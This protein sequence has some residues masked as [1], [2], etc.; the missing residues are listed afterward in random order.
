MKKLFSLFITFM[1]F[2]V[3]ISLLL[4]NLVLAQ[5][6]MYKNI[7]NRTV[8]T[9]DEGD[10]FITI[11]EGSTKT[12]KIEDEEFKINLMMISELD[13]Y[14]LIR[15]DG[16]SLPKMKTGDFQTSPK[17]IMIG[18]VQTYLTSKRSKPSIAKLVISKKRITAKEII[19][20]EKTEEKFHIN[21]IVLNE[22]GNIEQKEI[23]TKTEPE[24]NNTAKEIKNVSPATSTPAIT[25]A[26]KSAT[27]IATTVTPV[28][29]KNVTSTATKLQQK[30]VQEQKAKSWW[31]KILD[32]FYLI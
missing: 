11:N 30:P 1:A 29:R 13:G 6:S 16:E 5:E 23:E 14:V 8:E 19:E 18:V 9:L 12:L 31:Q 32:F 20:G 17:G 7:L 24:K 4:I 25:P 28:E 2:I 10:P 27:T 3:L 22:N 26:Q 21:E 15:V